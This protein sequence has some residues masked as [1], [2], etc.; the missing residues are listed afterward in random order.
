P[1]D[2]TDRFT[3]WPVRIARGGEVLAP[4]TPQDPAQII[5][6]R[7][8]AEFIVRQVERRAVGD[9]NATGPREPYAFG[10]MLGGIKDALGA[11][12][13][14]TWADREFLAAHEVAPWSQMP[15]WVPPV[16]EYAGFGRVSIVKAL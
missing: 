12:A 8:L 13:R 11:D 15:V 16:D 14:F 5:D 3:Y 4:G 7:D 2:P 1:G 10:E 6:A 9:F